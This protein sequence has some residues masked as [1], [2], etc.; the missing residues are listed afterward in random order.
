VL[1]P[2]VMVAIAGAG[3]CFFGHCL[4]IPLSAKGG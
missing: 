2:H 3:I 4:G 1:L